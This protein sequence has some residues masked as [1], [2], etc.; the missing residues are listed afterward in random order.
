MEKI[1]TAIYPT[2]FF[3]FRKL[4]S[5]NK[6][7]NMQ[8]NF[9][10]HFIWQRS[11]S[12]YQ[13]GIPT[14]FSDSKSES[15]LSY[16]FTGHNPNS[17]LSNFCLRKWNWK[18]K[19]AACRTTLTFTGQH[20]LGIPTALS[21]SESDFFLLSQ[22]NFH[23]S[24][25]TSYH[26]PEIP[27]ALSESESDLFCWTTFT[28]TLTGQHLNIHLGSQLLSQKGDFCLFLQSRCGTSP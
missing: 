23:F 14:I 28:F 25:L 26:P 13:P 16:I 17:Y 10:F 6:V 27:T 5:F 1:Q 12:I 3:F 20:P 7:V 8:N 24:W 11:K 4:K 21:E 19:W 22:F 2:V 18:W 15:D 9:H